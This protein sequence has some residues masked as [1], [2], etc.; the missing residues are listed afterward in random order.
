M[1]EALKDHY[2]LEVARGLSN[3][4]V[5][6]WPKFPAKRFLKEVSRGFGELELMDRVRHISAGLST[7]LPDDF[8]R[9]CR[10]VKKA[11]GPPLKNTEGN[12]MEPFRYLPYGYWVADKG[13]DHPKSALKLQVELTRRCTSEFSVRPFLSTHYE[14]TLEFLEGLVDD[15]CPHVRRWV[16]E[17]TRPHLPWGKGVGR[18]AEKPSD[19]LHLLEYLRDDEHVYVR[20]SVANHLNDLS[21]KNSELLIKLA[22]RWSKSAPDGR[23]WILKHALRTLIKKGDVRALSI[24]GYGREPKIEIDEESIRPA[25]VKEGGVTT[26][27]WVL[28]SLAKRKQPLMVDLVVEY[29][30]AGGKIYCKT[31]KLKEMELGAKEEMEMQKKLSLK[32]LSTRK[33][34]PGLHRVFLLINGRKF[35]LGEFELLD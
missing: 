3:D 32:D 34:D 24:L 28:R 33:H 4:L 13:L 6:A 8:E 7:C 17:G 11:L 26:L 20:K 2:G 1:A 9:S 5:K 14:Q 10:I 15:P 12:G 21:R 31:F 18:L 30:R 23:R 25:L 16:S 19:H 27:S 35:G 29:P 22:K